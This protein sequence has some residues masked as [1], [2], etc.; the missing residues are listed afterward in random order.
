M[1]IIANGSLYFRNIC[2]RIEMNPG[3][4]EDSDKKNSIFPNEQ[5]DDPTGL[6]WAIQTRLASGPYANATTGTSRRTG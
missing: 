3:F 2:D 4:Q 1:D 6:K 5:A